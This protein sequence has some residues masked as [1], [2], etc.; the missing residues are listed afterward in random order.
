MQAAEPN[1]SNSSPQEM[2]PAALA[3]ANVATAPGFGTRGWTELFQV[4]ADRKARG[5]PGD[6]GEV[7]NAEV[8]ILQ[9]VASGRRR[10][11]RLMPWRVLHGGAGRHDDQNED[12][13]VDR[14]GVER[15]QTAIG[16]QVFSRLGDERGPAA[17][18]GNSHAGH[19]SFVPRKPQH[20]GRD[21]NDVCQAYTET[22]D[23]PDARDGEG[24]V[25]AT[26]AG[27]H[28]AAAEGKSAED[29]AFPRSD[30]GQQPA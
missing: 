10:G 26:K 23:Q 25:I 3:M 30:A 7:Q 17:E 16:H 22:A 13:A 8:P 4:G 5:Q 28:P 27:Q 14:E 2:R 21:R 20:A 18:A 9:R 29:R 15:D 19:Q 11:S 1:R 6:H 24:E 12:R